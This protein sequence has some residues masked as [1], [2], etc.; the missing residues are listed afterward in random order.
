[1]SV[2]V[3][4]WDT[5]YVAHFLVTNQGEPWDGWTLTFTVPAG[6][7][8]VHGWNGVWSQ[9]DDQITVTSESW[10][11]SVGTGQSVQPGHQAS[12]TGT[13]SFTDFAVNGEPC[14]VV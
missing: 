10:N 7:Q 12:H 13:V 3:D 2:T 11:A 14:T 6:V 9:Q 8:H 1:M 5:G 4:S